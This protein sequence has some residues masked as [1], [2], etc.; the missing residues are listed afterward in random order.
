MERSIQ[1]IKRYYGTRLPGIYDSAPPLFS[2][3]LSFSVSHSSPAPLGF[4]LILDILM[5]FLFEHWIY[6]FF[7][8]WGGREG[9]RVGVRVR[10]WG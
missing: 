10:A 8:S 2:L 1:Y 3:L 6:I 7:F 9:G 4:Y 5:T